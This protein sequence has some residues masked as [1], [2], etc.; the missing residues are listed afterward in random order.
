MASP[1]DRAQTVG[2]APLGHD[3]GVM[4]AVTKSQTEHCRATEA[5]TVSVTRDC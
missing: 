5:R 1:R 4:T 2:G 3:D